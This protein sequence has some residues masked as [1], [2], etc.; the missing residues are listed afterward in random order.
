MPD[1]LL[2]ILTGAS[3]G[4]LA[5]FAYFK[6]SGEQWLQNKF[7]TQLEESKYRLNAA[8]DRKI[9]LHNAEYDALPRLWNLIVQVD[10]ATD[11]FTRISSLD[12]DLDELDFRH[13]TD[14]LYSS[15][16]NEEDKDRIIAA[17][18]KTKTY[19]S[20]STFHFRQ[21]SSIK[22]AECINYHNLN[23]IYFSAQL[24]KSVNDYLESVL[25]SQKC[26]RVAILEGKVL[27][28]RGVIQVIEDLN[29]IRSAKLDEVEKVIR[30]RIWSEID[31]Q[32]FAHKS[33]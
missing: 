5:C 4:A 12:Y 23:A 1:W 26:M 20:L 6:V 2:Q 3:S 11:S 14:F 27:G 32:S 31:G 21:Q 9:K 13:L 19:V 18:Q 15:G 22:F 8:L 29:K 25:N 7:D 30:E 24:T 33:K 17:E 16:L 28:N 10:S